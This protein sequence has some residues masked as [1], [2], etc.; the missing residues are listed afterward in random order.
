MAGVVISGPAHLGVFAGMIDP[1]RVHIVPNS[2]G[3]D[4]FVDEA[5]V[6][7]KFERTRPLRVLYLSSMTA[8]KGYLDLAEAWLSLS[9]DARSRIQL[10]FAGKFDADADRRQFEERLAGQEGVRYHGLVDAEAKRRLLAQAHVFCLPTKM[11]EGQ[12]I[13]ILEAYASGCVVVTT[14][15]AGIRDVFRDGVNGV[16]VSAGSPASLAAV[17][18]RAPDEAPRLRQMA[19]ENRRTA[20]ERYRAAT[21][22]AALTRLLA[23][24]AT[25]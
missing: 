3:D 15:Q 20:G 4:V 1:A 17:L 19:I 12:P 9:R 6:V 14:G 10:D 21:F 24:G 22:T 2:A 5:E 16:E 8:P 11:L 23:S 7:H 13:S 25:A 18:Q